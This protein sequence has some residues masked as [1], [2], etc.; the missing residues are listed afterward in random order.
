MKAT[1]S[2]LELARDWYLEAVEAVPMDRWNGPTLCAGWTPSHVVAHVATGDQ[3]F[4]GVILDATGQDRSGQDLPVDF[5][6]RKRRFE[7][8]AQKEPAE[9]KAAAHREAE[10]TVALILEAVEKRPSTVVDVPFGQV[11]MNVVRA[12]RLNEY[13]IHGHD[14]A[15]AIGKSTPAPEWF[16]D[17]ALGDAITMMSRLHQRSP[18]KGKTASFHIHR[19]DGQ[20]EWTLRAEGGQ[21]VAEEGHGKADAAF[22]G[23]GQSLYWLVMGRGRPED[24]AV[25]VHGDLGIAAAFKEWFPGP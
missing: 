16:S 1:T 9:L 11:P 2:R 13:I 19:T 17:R 12:L 25:E 6:D 21:A 4:R 5:A 20:G 18:H 3:L 8:M 15:P 10:Q 22:R 23:P 24:V 14:L 7:E